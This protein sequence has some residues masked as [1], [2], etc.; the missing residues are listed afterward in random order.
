[1]IYYYILCI[2]WSL[3]ARINYGIYYYR[4]RES[5]LPISD[6][7]LRSR[8]VNVSQQTPMKLAICLSSNNKPKNYSPRLIQQQKIVLTCYLFYST[9]IYLSKGNRDTGN[10]IINFINYSVFHLSYISLNCNSTLLLFL[11]D[12]TCTYMVAFAGRSL[13]WNSIF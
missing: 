1:M 3:L 4:A 6:A 12:L 8:R 11:S 9:S 13:F 5:Y 7:N 2:S 10:Y